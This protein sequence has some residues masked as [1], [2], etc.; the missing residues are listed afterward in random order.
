MANKLTSTKNK[1][2]IQNKNKMLE[3][4]EYDKGFFH[5]ESKLETKKMPLVTW[6]LYGDFLN[7]LNK[8]ISD[9]NQLQLLA[10]FNSWK[11]D[12]NFKKSV[13][14]DTVVVVTC[15]NLKIVFSTKNM[16]YQQIFRF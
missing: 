6:D 12:I 3:F 15:P 8:N 14:I 10:T 2:I 13:D 9:Q 16:V 4:K 5:N 1:N 7:Q 11:T